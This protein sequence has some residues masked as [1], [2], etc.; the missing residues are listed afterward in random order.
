MVYMLRVRGSRF[1]TA[2]GGESSS[3]SEESGVTVASESTDSSSDESLSVLIRFLFNL[4][5]PASHGKCFLELAGPGGGVA[6][7]GIILSSSSLSL[8]SSWNLRS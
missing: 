6:G 8:C 2:G 4:F 7:E 3:V 5:L 1:G